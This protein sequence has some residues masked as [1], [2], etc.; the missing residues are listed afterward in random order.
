MKMDVA[1]VHRRDRSPAAVAE[2]GSGFFHVGPSAFRARDLVF[3]SILLVSA[4]LDFLAAGLTRRGVGLRGEHGF[5][6]SQ[7]GLNSA[8]LIGRSPLAAWLQA[9][10]ATM[11]G[12]RGGSVVAPRILEWVLAGVLVYGLVTWLLGAR[13]GLLAGAVPGLIPVVSTL[14]WGRIP[15]GG[16]LAAILLSAWLTTRSAQTGQV[17]WLFLWAVLFGLGFDLKTQGAAPLL[18]CCGLLY[19]LAAKL[20]MRTRLFHLLP[21]TAIFLAVSLA[22][23][24]APASAPTA[25]PP[26]LIANCHDAEA[27]PAFCPQQCAHTTDSARTPDSPLIPCAAPPRRRGTL[28][29]G[30]SQLERRGA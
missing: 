21:T 18:L 8:A 19:L 3:A 5:F 15:D 13:A 28:N 6:P 24:P 2:P 4:I 10:S 17:R 25:N 23:A 29:A 20:P 7:F 9:V 22:W 27:G 16:L 30:A 1:P 11:L 12:S 26:F 14:G